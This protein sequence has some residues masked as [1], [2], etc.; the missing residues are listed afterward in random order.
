MIHEQND[1]LSTAHHQRKTKM[2]NLNPLAFS[3]EIGP[4]SASDLASEQKRIENGKTALYRRVIL[5]SLAIAAAGITSTAAI[6]W[7]GLEGQ[8]TMG[9]LASM[10]QGLG[11]MF[12]LCVAM[13]LCLEFGRLNQGIGEEN[14]LLGAEHRLELLSLD[15]CTQVMGWCR[16]HPVLASYQSRAV[17]DRLLVKGDLAA[18]QEWIHGSSE[19]QKQAHCAALRSPLLSLQTV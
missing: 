12:C 17:S 18:M 15:D 10:S 7:V 6:L 13:F 1:R 16:T 14:V 3:I 2:K 8:W 4:P 11:A 9:A 5:E 19:A